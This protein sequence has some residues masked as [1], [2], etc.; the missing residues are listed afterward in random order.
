[1][2]VLE[3]H[4]R[5]SPQACGDISGPVWRDECR[6]LLAENQ[7]A[8]GDGQVGLQTCMQT[9]FRRQCSWHLVRASALASL[10]SPPAEAEA[11]LTMFEGVKAIPDAARQFWLIRFREENATGRPIDERHCEALVE[12]ASCRMAV[13]EHVQH[14]LSA[15]TSGGKE[16]RCGRPAGAR[17][18][19]KGVPLWTPGPIA[20]S[21]EA[22]WVKERCPPE[23]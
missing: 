18:H 15:P 12:P 11:R 8:A 23:P 7:W 22:R 6:F 16:D 2:T 1:M 5:L 13:V 19:R 17:V 3:K 20:M 9:R 4:D 21:A 14:S 10:D